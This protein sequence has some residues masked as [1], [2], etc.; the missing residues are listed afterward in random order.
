M[1]HKKKSK[2]QLTKDYYIR[3]LLY[4][5]TKDRTINRTKDRTTLFILLLILYIHTIIS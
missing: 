1:M 2:K 3:G 4:K 5:G